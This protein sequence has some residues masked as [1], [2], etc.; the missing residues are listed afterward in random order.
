MLA[1]AGDQQEV[2]AALIK[3]GALNAQ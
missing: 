3:A 1:T 2:R